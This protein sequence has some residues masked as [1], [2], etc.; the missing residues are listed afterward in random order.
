MQFLVIKKGTVI[1][2]LAACLA[3]VS[4][5]AWWLLKAGDDVVFN[6]V[7][8]KTVREV[9]MVTGEFAATLPTGKKI[10]AYRWDPGTIFLEK[11][12]KVRLIIYGVNGNEHPFKIENTSIKGTVKKGEETVLDLS[13]EKEGVYRLICEVH[14]DIE[15]NGPMIAYIIVD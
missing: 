7:S 8:G 3:I 10:E 11:K 9:H 6:Q 5:A 4:A 13:F 2:F 15:H 12:E 14:P 1:L